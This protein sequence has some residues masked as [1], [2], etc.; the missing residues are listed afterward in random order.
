MST[1]SAL[2]LVEAIAQRAAA[3]GVAARDE[4]L[5]AQAALV[6][7]LVDQV[8]FHHPSERRVAALHSQLGEELARFAELASG[9]PKHAP[10]APEPLDVL[11]V[12]DDEATLRAT[13]A[14]LRELGHPCRSAASAQDAVRE[15]E[16]RPAEIVI[17]DWNMPGMSGLDLCRTLKHRDPH[18]YV[19][20]VTAF[21]DEARL[22]DGVRRGVDDFLPKP[23]DVDDLAERLAAAER[24]VRAVRMLG[25]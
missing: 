5:R 21:Y 7:A 6:R 23:V 4:G 9:P 18:A 17:S 24:L 25:A 13:A 11:V 22:M 12:D 2:T 19:V 10:G 16:L 14:I 3:L 1:Q 8:D 15:Y 20:L